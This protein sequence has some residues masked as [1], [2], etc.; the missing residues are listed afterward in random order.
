[1]FP[2]LHYGTYGDAKRMISSANETFI[3]GTVV[4]DKVFLVVYSSDDP[5]APAI[6]SAWATR[7]EAQDWIDKDINE[8]IVKAK[9]S[10]RLYPTILKRVENGKLI[11]PFYRIWELEIRKKTA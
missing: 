10:P 7:E 3:K 6:H 8:Y 5:H 4:M 11:N 1:M 2:L 9:E